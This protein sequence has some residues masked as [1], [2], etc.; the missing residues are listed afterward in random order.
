MKTVPG[1]MTK[2]FQQ[3]SALSMCVP[4][5]PEVGRYTGGDCADISCL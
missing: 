2:M 5:I 4:A 1:K 3:K